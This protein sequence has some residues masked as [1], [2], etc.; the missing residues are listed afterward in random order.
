MKLLSDVWLAIEGKGKEGGFLRS[1][2]VGDETYETR[3]HV[4]DTCLPATRISPSSITTLVHRFNRT[5]ERRIA[6]RKRKLR[7]F[8]FT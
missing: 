8:S 4:Y 7:T 2:G 1:R 3:L 5:Y 6:W